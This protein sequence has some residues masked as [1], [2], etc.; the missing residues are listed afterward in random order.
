MP[1]DR[2]VLV[3]SWRKYWGTPDRIAVVVAGNWIPGIAGGLV[4]GLE[5]P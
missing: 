1:A 4:S 2:R 3:T 5:P